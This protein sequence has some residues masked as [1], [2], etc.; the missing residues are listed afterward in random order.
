MDT[1]PCLRQVAISPSARWSA[2][3]LFAGK[4]VVQKIRVPA[5]MNQSQNH[6]IP[7][8]KF[9]LKKPGERAAIS[10]WKSMRSDMVTSLSPDNRSNSFLDAFVE[11]ITQTL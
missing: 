8:F 1:L 11:I 7:V 6:E 9:V 3:L 5:G 4:P 2:L 10:A